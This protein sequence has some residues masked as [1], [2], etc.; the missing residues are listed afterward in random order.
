MLSKMAYQRTIPSQALPTYIILCSLKSRRIRRH[1][2]CPPSPPR[3]LHD[4]LDQ[5][6]RRGDWRGP[7]NTKRLA[8][9]ISVPNRSWHLLGNSCPRGHRRYHTSRHRTAVTAAMGHGTSLTVVFGV[10]SGP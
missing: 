9:R 10:L 4:S 7:R 1:A 8:V 3:I 6:D 5:H 2:T